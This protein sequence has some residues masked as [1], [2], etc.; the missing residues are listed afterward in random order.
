MDYLFSL[1]LVTQQDYSVG[2]LFFVNTYEVNMMVFRLY[3]FF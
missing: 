1:V 3:Y 2:F